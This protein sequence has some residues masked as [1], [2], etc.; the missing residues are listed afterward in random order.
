MWAVSCLLPE[1]LEVMEAWGFRYLT[2]L[3]WVKPSIGPGRR[4]RNRHELLLYGQKGK[5]PA[6]DPEDLPDSVIEAPR[7]RHSEKPAVV[8]ELIERM[9]PRASKVELFARGKARPGW[10]VWGNEG[11]RP[12]GGGNMSERLLTAEEVAAFLAVKVSW[13]REATRDGRLPHL[14]LGRY[15]R[16][17]LS[18]VDSWL[19]E[20]E[21]GGR[22]AFPAQK[23]LK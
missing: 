18:D 17:R 11:G 13:V 10:V 9:Y 5:L 2:N 1:A 15:R 6:P 20:Q 12:G 22:L 14:R 8:Y 7:G 3:V 21:V 16:Y 4:V 23:S 19:S